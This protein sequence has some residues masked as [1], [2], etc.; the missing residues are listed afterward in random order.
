ME[1]KIDR[2]ELLKAVSRVQSIIERKSNMPVL[3]TILFATQGKEGGIRI[4]ATDLELGFQEAVPAEVIKEGNTTISGRKLFEILKESNANQFHI[5]V[6]E[7]TRVSI[8]DGVARFAL[9][10]IPADEFPTFMEPEAVESIP[11]EG[12]TLCEMIN[13]TIYAVTLEEAGFKLSG[14]FTEKRT[15]DQGTHMLRMVATDGHRLSLIDKSFPGL[16]TLD[17]GNGVMIPKKGMSELNKMG[18]EGGVVH[19]GF[20]EKRC[21][22]KRGKTLLIMRLLETKFPDYQAVIPKGEQSAIEVDRISLL[23]G[24]RKM[25]ILSN[26]R[27]RAV[28][29]TLESNQLDLMSTNPELGEAEENM[30]IEYNGERIEAGFNPKYFIDILQSMES[31]SVNLFFSDSSKPCVI[32]GELDTGFIGLIMPMRV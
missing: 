4:S 18:N 8:T 26:E 1:I 13:K 7:N 15:D 9:A 16:E 29:V 14:V 19:V 2:N 11:I 32:K 20:K 17:M 10:C 23:E 22:A 28:R 3:S 6:K 12:E 25:L 5:K 21:I 24:M 27:Y 30:N 31:E